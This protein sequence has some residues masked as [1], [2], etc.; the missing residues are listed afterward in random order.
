[1]VMYIGTEAEGCKK[2]TGT[3]EIAGGAEMAN[4]TKQPGALLVEMGGPGPFK[5]TNGTGATVE[6]IVYAPNAVVKLSGN[7]QF[8]GGILG[9]EVFVEGSS[10]I[11]SF[12][13]EAEALADGAASSY[14]RETWAQCL[15]GPGAC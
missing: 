15:S 12:S 9:N 7:V 5:Y 13:S 1:V 11:Y 2:G 4:E 14:S 3:F 10:K 6:A 8:T